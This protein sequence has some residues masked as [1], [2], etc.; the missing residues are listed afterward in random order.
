[1]MARYLCDLTNA[2]WASI[3]PRRPCPNR[4]G[5][6]R[7]VDL[8]DVW[9]AIGY[10]AAAGCTQSPI[11]KDFPPVSTVCYYFYRWR[12]SGLLAE[13]NRELVLIVCKT[14]GRKE[15]PTAPTA[16]A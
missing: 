11:P 14:A 13:V 3:T 1:M 4:L 9:D 15:Q 12:E 7:H 8:R 16:K 10:M 5:R 6:H 2:E